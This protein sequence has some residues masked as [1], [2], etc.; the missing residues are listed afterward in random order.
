M[1][2]LVRDQR[3]QALVAGD[4]GG[5]REREQ[6]IL[7][8]AERE[9]RRQHQ[10]VV[11]APAVGPVQAPPRPAIIASVSSNSL[12]RGVDHRRLR[13]HARARPDVAER[14]VAR[15]QRDQVRRNRGWSRRNAAVGPAHAALITARRPCG[16]R[17]PRRV[18]D[19]DAGR[20]L[21]RDPAARVDRLR[22]RVEERM[23]LARGLRRIEPLEAGCRRRGRV[24]DAHQGPPPQPDVQRRAE[25]RIGGAELER[26]RVL[27]AVDRESR[28]S[29]IS[30]SPDDPVEV[31]GRDALRSSALEMHVEIEIEVANANPVGARVGVDVHRFMIEFKRPILLVSR[32]RV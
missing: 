9:A 17:D 19:A 3:D 13:V 11:A 20:V 2:Q 22:L 31:D 28:V 8:A 10:Q 32:T 7:H 18:G 5:R 30:S 4:H 14:Q 12:R 23:L 1:R 16:V 15:R 6:R 26:G 24:A 25:D 27:D 29:R 21:Q